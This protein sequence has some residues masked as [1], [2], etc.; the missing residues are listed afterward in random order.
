M[1]T[2]IPSVCFQTISSRAALIVHFM[3]LFYPLFQTSD[4]AEKFRIESLQFCNFVVS[5]R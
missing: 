4:A 5:S 3:K 2:S 1:K